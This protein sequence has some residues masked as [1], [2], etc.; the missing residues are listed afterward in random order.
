MTLWSHVTKGVSYAYHE[1]AGNIEEDTFGLGW[2]KTGCGPGCQALAEC[3]HGS[4]CVLPHGLCAG[5]V[6]GKP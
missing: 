5:T 4:H 2:R 3:Q 1:V 6:S